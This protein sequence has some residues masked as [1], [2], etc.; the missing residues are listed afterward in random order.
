MLIYFGDFSCNLRRRTAN[1]KSTVGGLRSG[2]KLTIN[3]HQRQE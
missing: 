1:P 2:I 3:A